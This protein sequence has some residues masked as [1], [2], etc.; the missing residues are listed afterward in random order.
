MATDHF[1]LSPADVEARFQD[2]QLAARASSGRR[3]PAVSA[4][5]RG[6]LPDQRR[7]RQRFQQPSAERSGPDHLS[8]ALEH[9]ADRSGDQRA[10]D[11]DVRGRVAQRADGQRRGAHRTRRCQSVAARTERVRRLPAGRARGDA[12][13]AGARRA[14]QSRA[15]QNAP[16]QQLLDD[17]ASFQRVLFTNASRACAGR[18]RQRRHE[19]LPDRRSATQRARAAG[20]GRLR[21]RV[22][23]VPRRTRAVERPG[24]RS[25]AS[26]TSR[27]SVR[28]RSTR[29]TPARFAFAACPPQLARNARTYEITLANG[30]RSAAP[31]P[32]PAARC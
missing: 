17:L 15:G 12:A 14:D 7:Q 6:R 30:A 25:S 3:R 10:V 31:A 11:R 22:R 26:T 8:A 16:P 2:L 13:G 24:A 21:A 18:R 5:R 4:D 23:P 28:V 32:I 27:P 29:S 1:Q 20:Q 19:P 9:Q